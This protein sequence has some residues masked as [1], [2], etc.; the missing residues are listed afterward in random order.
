MKKINP[1]TKNKLEELQSKIEERFCQEKVEVLGE[2]LIYISDAF[3]II[4]DIFDE[5]MDEVSE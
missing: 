1:L 2:D 5:F 4:E 3:F